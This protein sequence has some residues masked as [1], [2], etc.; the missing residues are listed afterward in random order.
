MASRNG[1]FSGSDIVIRY[2]LSNGT[3]VPNDFVLLGA[4]RD[5]TAPMTRETVDATHRGSSNGWRNRLQTLKTIDGS[6]NG[7]ATRNESDNMAAL[8][9]YT[10]ETNDQSCGWI[11]IRTPI[12]NGQVLVDSIPVVFNSFD[13]DGTGLD[14][15]VTWTFAF[16]SDGEPSFSKE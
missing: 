4:V 3:A 16:E 5:H 14:A 7:V 6:V 2:S 1:T 12:E 10:R 13:F 9:D 8:R 15:E 11:E